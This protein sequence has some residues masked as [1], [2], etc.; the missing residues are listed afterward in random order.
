MS[1]FEWGALVAVVIGLFGL[2]IKG[3]SDD[4]TSET[5]EIINGFSQKASKAG[6]DL[7]DNLGASSAVRKQRVLDWLR[8]RTAD[9][10]DG[11]SGG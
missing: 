8:K 7:A 6:T 2:F 11:D 5:Q 1:D 10:G 9:N 3:R 4:R